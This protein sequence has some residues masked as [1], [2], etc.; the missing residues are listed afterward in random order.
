MPDAT[1]LASA[2]A[3]LDG[4]EREALHDALFRCCA[5]ERWVTAM[6]EQCPFAAPE[7]LAMAARAAFVLLRRK[8]W[9]EAFAGHPLIGADPAVLLTKFAPT[10]AW[11]SEEQAGVGSAP[12][13]VI[14]ELARKNRCYQERFGFA[15]IV[16][17]SGKSAEAL[18]AALDAR[19]ENAPAVELALAAAEQEKITLLRLEKLA[20]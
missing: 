5:S 11:S 4:L 6:L 3:L 13:D 2:Q 7:G 8:D 14:D 20:R 9:L 10:A 12:R 17:A 18:L 19:L 16:C 15:F 1:A